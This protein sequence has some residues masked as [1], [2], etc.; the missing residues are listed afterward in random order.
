M[1]E[2]P[3]PAGSPG[4]PG[5]PGPAAPR[6]LFL[7]EIYSTSPRL[8]GGVEVT[9][10]NLVEGLA[11][12]GVV[13][14]APH[15][16]LLS[17]G[18]HREEHARRRREVVEAPPPPPPPGVVVLRPPYLHVPFLWGLTGP[19][20]LVVLGLWAAWARAGRVDVVH[21]HR[22]FPMGAVAVVLGWL[23]RRPSVVTVYG[24]GIHTAAHRGPL[25]VRFWTRFAVR[26]A[27]RV[28]GVARS[29]LAG[30]VE[31]G[32]P[33]GRVRL[34]PSG[35]DL[36]RFAPG[37]AGAARRQ[38]GLPEDRRVLLC[39]SNFLPV[40]GHAVLIE[41]FRAICARRDDVLLV[42]TSDGPERPAVEEAVR[43]HGLTGRVLFPG[44][45]SRAEI[46]LY[47]AAADVLALPSHDEG[48]PLSVLEALAGG[49][50]VVATAVG[51]TPEVIGDGHHGLLVPPRDP[52]ALAEALAAAL[53]RAWDP[54]AL[55]RRAEE[56]GWPCVVERLRAV[57]REVAAGAAADAG[58][59]PP[60]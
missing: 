57:Y 37:D 17:P 60:A 26:H 56:F 5:S 3:S 49:R 40:K 54:A 42:L 58:E 31:L 15:P 14:L 48:M 55:R 30:T 28:V 12:D 11:G 19:L 53:E 27:A 7:V 51:G 4:S 21:G 24:Y 32:A 50:P 20:Q 36:A 6:P 2:R 39:T 10:R 1:S 41:A 59:K 52:Q 46:P 22:A 25:P 29:L 23:L 18:R 43:R 9:I 38:L 44:L 16:L 35:V 13:V 8:L 45:V 33:S 47:V 34:V